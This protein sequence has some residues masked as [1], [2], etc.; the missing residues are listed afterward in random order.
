MARWAKKYS[1][2]QKAQ[3][4]AAMLD[5]GLTANETARRATA[6]EAPFD[7]PF[8]LPASTVRVWKSNAERRYG[9]RAH[10]AAENQTHSLHS[11]EHRTRSKIAATLR[12]ID[13]DSGDAENRL[14]VVTKTLVELD[15]IQRSPMNK[16]DTPKRQRKKGLADRLETTAPAEMRGS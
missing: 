12:T 16:P 3:A 10:Q 7:E 8:N 6:G 15:K 13:P 1:D 5:D 4:I 9:L 14:L 2:Q 11:L